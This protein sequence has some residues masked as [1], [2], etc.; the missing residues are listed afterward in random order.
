MNGGTVAPPEDT[1]FGIGYGDTQTIIKGG[2]ESLPN[3]TNMKLKNEDQLKALTT[4]KQSQ[5][6]DS[7]RQS[8]VYFLKPNT[9]NIYLFNHEKQEFV[10]ESLKY[11]GPPQL[12]PTNFTTCQ[13]VQNDAIYMVGGLQQTQDPRDYILLPYCRMIDA[14][15]Q[16][17]EKAQMK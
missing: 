14:N 8:T 1:D 9:P 5:F 4:S 15:L 16:C 2:G 13:L 11:Q 3:L 12:H 17:T 6:Y 7:D 10:A